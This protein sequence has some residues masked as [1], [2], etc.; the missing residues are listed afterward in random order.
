VKP[1]V[2]TVGL[3]HTTAPVH[4]REQIAAARCTREEARDRLLLE[5]DGSLLPETLL[6]STCNRT[7]IYAV[8][9]DCARGEQ[10]L[11]R[12]FAA[13]DSFPN[14]PGDY[15]YTYSDRAAAAHLF[16][17]AGGIDS[18]LVGEFEI[19]GQI[20][21]AYN[22]AVQKKSVGAILHQL[23]QQAINVGKRARSET[24]IGTG[25]TSVAYAAVALARKHLGELAGRR[26]LVIGAGMMGRRAA[27]NLFADGACTVVVA[28]R[29]LSHAS[30]LASEIGSHAISFDDLPAAL[31]EAD[32]V[33]SATKA[34]HLILTSGQVAEA[35]RSRPNKPLCLVDIAVPRDIEPEVSRLE[36]VRLWNIDDL[37]DLVS[38]SRAERIRAIDQVRSIVEAEADDFWHWYLGRRA[39]PVLG[40]LHARAEA[41]RH[42]ELERTLR[43]LDH[44]NLSE[45]DRAAI[46]ALS[47]SLVRKLLS[48]PRTKLKDHMQN[49]D[50]QAYLDMLR[51]VFDLENT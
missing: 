38:A 31:S 48:A 16:A 14:G 39:A 29:N 49:G 50:G 22:A 24:S 5:L 10:E 12:V 1:F 17:V 33:I 8:A 25:A 32:L 11:K 18:M 35:M 30:E 44:L 42:A 36:N 13:H 4:V 20:R 9:T 6:L 15:L 7:E 2:L 43:R 37:K 27:K 45:R 19:L 21:E 51:E 34:P 3:N 26:A 47:S 23:L 46:I 41:I 28:S 40:E